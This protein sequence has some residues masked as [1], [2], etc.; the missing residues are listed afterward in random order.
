MTSE[1]TAGAGDMFEEAIALFTPARLLANPLASGEG[2]RVAL[3][4]TG[5][6]RKVI[7]ARCRRRGTE[8]VPLEGAL[9]C[10]WTP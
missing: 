1:P 8:P 5:V 2:V 9:F 3:I 4:D 6:E 7:E 10:R